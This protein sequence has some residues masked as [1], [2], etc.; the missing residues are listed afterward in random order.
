MQQKTRTILSELKEA[1]HFHKD[2]EQAIVMAK[3]MKNKFAFLGIQQPMRKE[4]SAD[5]I[6]S[7]RPLEPR[8]IIA[9]AAAL[10]KLPEREFQY[11]GLE[12]L[13]ACRKKF[14]SD[15]L[16]LFGDL[17][18]AKPWW[19]SIDFIATKLFGTYYQ[20]TKSPPQMI[21]WS[22]SQDLWQNRVALLFQLNYKTAT[23]TKLLFDIINRLKGN[24]D[25]FI[26]K[27]IGWSLR[28]YYRTDP[29]AVKA[30]VEQ[31][32]IEGLAKREALKHALR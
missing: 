9:T 29:K 26:Q 2:V 23:D 5:F 21:A 31:S 22:K 12:L 28:Q 7:M 4:L 6:R 20:Q 17:V 30:F 24:K 8:E 16:S 18:V 25:F 14:D 3:Y 10:W 1:M 19:D 13:Y 32:G 15:F 11:I 27:A